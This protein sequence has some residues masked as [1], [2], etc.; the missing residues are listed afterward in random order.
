M[1]VLLVL[2]ALANAP[3][4]TIDLNGT[5]EF[6]Q[7]VA[8]FP[9]KEFTRKI[10]VPG[11]IHLATPRIEEYD[12]FFK[13]P[14]KAEFSGTRNI[15]K[16]DYTPKYNWYR[17]TVKVGKE[18]EGREAVLTIKKS[19][20]VTQV[21][22]NGIDLGTY[23]E[24]YTPIDVV[25]TRALKYG[26]ENEILLKV[27]DRYWLPSHAAGGTDKEKEHYLPG[28][29]DDVSLS[30]TDKM[31]V[32]RV[33]A[34]PNL[35]EKKVT[36][37]AK[38]WNLNIFQ[39]PKDPKGDRVQYEVKVYEK[40]SRKQVASAQGASHILRDQ[41]GE[42]SV[43]MPLP[44]PHAWSPDDPFLYTAEVTVKHSGKES[45]RVE[46]AFGMRDF[47]RRGKSFYLN[48]E[49]IYLRGSNI[50]LQRFFEDPDCGN[51][52]WDK[53]WV[54]KMLVDIPKSLDWNSMRI[55]VSIA[56]DFWYDYADE[57]GLLFQNEWLY[58]QHHGWDDQI[59]KEY[60][61]W[62]WAD[63]SHP[64]IAIWDG[65]NENTHQYMGNVLIPELKQLDPT[66]FWDAGYMTASQLTDDEMDEPH[67]YLG[68]PNDKEIK[69]TPYPLGNLHYKPNIVQELE[70]SASAQLVNEYSWIWLWRDGT[71]SKLTI[72]V[73]NHY[74]GSNSTV[75]QRRAFQ[76]YWLQC[77][78]ELLRSNKEVAGLL[79]FCYLTN[80]YGYTGD[81]FIGDIKELT[82]SPALYWLKH[83][84][85]PTTVFLNLTDERYAK[86]QPAHTPG[87][88]LNFTLMA[89]NDVAQQKAGKVTVRLLNSKGVAVFKDT[90]PV[91][92]A[93]SDRTEIPY[94]IK[95]PKAADGYLLETSFTENG[96][97]DKL[98]S[99][100]YLK[101]GKQDQYKFY[102]T[103]LPENFTGVSA[104]K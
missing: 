29:W 46:R 84:F 10:P 53:E 62:V 60:T 3:R 8:A 64:S 88:K 85:A 26:Q 82:P 89:V 48:G 50:T 86:G 56:P 18:Q 72:P 79:A 90:V 52:V 20:Y 66:R 6:E 104:R 69:D 21:F 25:L 55:C 34:L 94:T 61:D 47:E 59:R 4:T 44:D 41:L 23:V 22:V 2:P 75:E 11:L 101:V 42:I 7:T 13:R 30:F 93:A 33:L 37:K 99:R 70:K 14:E 28:I 36:V 16:L 78:T 15:L 35:K 39:T 83:C 32:S 19:Q 68:R 81:W 38:I 100:R 102:E 54:K 71:P 67:V 98:L 96:R 76:A 17:R 58:W 57:Y 77:E 65:L 45:D 73:Y 24:C 80:N 12:K 49:K 1:A 51:L 40:K 27:A 9:P 91:T 103:P 31:W 5:W 43:E 92:I 63:G 95:L 87:E 97:Q 74:M